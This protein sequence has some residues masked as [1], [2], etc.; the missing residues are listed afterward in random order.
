MGICFGKKSSCLLVEHYV[1]LLFAVF[2]VIRGNGVNFKYL[3]F[4]ITMHVLLVRYLCNFHATSVS[5]DDGE[6]ICCRDDAGSDTVVFVSSS[7][8]SSACGVV[9]TA[10]TLTNALAHNDL[11]GRY[12]YLHCNKKISRCWDSATREP[13]VAEII[14]IEVQNSTRMVWF[15]SVYIGLYRILDTATYRL[16]YGFNWHA[17]PTS[18]RVP[19]SNILLY[20]PPTLQTD[21]RTDVRLV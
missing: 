17:E 4:V 21:R 2:K 3:L 20:I 11:E 18:R 19:I 13:L 12:T 1:S 9:Y 6:T 15:S 8:S 7:S 10:E 16:V 5:P 14:A